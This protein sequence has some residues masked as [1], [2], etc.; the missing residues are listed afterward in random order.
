MLDKVTL[1]NSDALC[2]IIAYYITIEKEKYSLNGN[3]DNNL[4]SLYHSNLSSFFVDTFPVSSLQSVNLFTRIVENKNKSVAS[5]FY[6]KYTSPYY[7]RILRELF[8][9]QEFP[10]HHKFFIGYRYQSGSMIEPLKQLM[11]LKTMFNNV[12]VHA[13]LELEAKENLQHSEVNTTPCSVDYVHLFDAG[14]TGSVTTVLPIPKC[15]AVYS[16]YD[17]NLITKCNFPHG[18]PNLIYVQMVSSFDVALVLLQFCVVRRIPNLFIETGNWWSGTLDSQS[19]DQL[20][21]QINTELEKGT[22][23]QL[24]LLATNRE[25]R[26]QTQRRIHFLKYTIP[27]LK[28][29]FVRSRSE[30]FSSKAFPFLSR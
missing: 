20:I 30:C 24:N 21:S 8:S 13:V 12:V 26:K 29:N 17:A 4:Y 22:T 5:C 2:T 19:N 15:E 27:R 28:V 9:Q 25:E 1:L 7:L 14:Y 3:N 16:Y 11:E 18:V 23:F 10:P 6:Y